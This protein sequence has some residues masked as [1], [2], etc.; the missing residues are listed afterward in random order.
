MKST[1]NVLIC[2]RGKNRPAFNK[3]VTFEHT[4]ED[5]KKQIIAK[6][7]SNDNDPICAND[8][9]ILHGRPPVS[10]RRFLHPSC[11]FDEMTGV[12]RWDHSKYGSLSEPLSETLKIVK[13]REG[14]SK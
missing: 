10:R 13:E 4:P 6:L 9:Y 7:L 11:A 3:R 8:V 1:E 5:D 14:M 12:I 2:Y